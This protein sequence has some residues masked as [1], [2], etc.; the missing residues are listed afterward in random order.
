MFKPV[1]DL[2]T[3]QTRKSVRTTRATPVAAVNGRLPRVEDA[4]AAKYLKTLW[5]PR[6]MQADA[7]A[8]I[9][10]YLIR[11]GRLSPAQ[12]SYA[13][14]YSP[15]WWSRAMLI[16]ALDEDALG[17]TA[18]GNI[19]AAGVCDT[20]RAPSLAAGWKG[21]Q[22]KYVPSGRRRHWNKAAELL[23][24]EVGLIQ[25]STATYCG[26]A[27]SLAKLDQR[28]YV[29]N[30]R[31]LFA[32]RYNQAELQIVEAVAASGVNI[33]NFVNLL[34]VFNDL[35]LDAV[36]RADGQIGGYQL[37]RIGSA[38]NPRSRFALK[39][40]ALF[41]LAN[42]IHDRRYESLGS[43]PLVRNSGTPTKKTSYKILGKA[44][45]LLIAAASELRS[46]NLG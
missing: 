46:A 22:I 3:Y 23:L 25:R 37:G 43:H 9:G 19:V 27:H 28:V 6:T 10:V 18:L 8:A 7:Q 16:E 35:L 40:P 4:N 13:C 17:A 26:I 33:T 39:F 32:L 2:S 1:A 31:R 29:L 44:R 30:W 14:R 42:E 15:S 34:D 20:G 36:F 45:N 21:F 5:V 11:V 38:L 41:A 24:R 12:V